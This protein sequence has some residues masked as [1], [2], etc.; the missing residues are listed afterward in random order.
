MHIYIYLCLCVYIWNLERWYWW[1]CL[2]DSN[3]DK[4][5]EPAY[6]HGS[7]EEGEGGMNGESNT[8]TYMLPP[9]KYVATGN[10][11]YYSENSN[12]SSATSERSGKG[13]EGE[14][15]LR[16]REYMCTCDWLLL[17]YG[18][19][20]HN[21]V[22]ILQLKIN[23]FICIYK[24]RAVNPRSH[25]FLWGSPKPGLISSYIKALTIR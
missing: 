17:I 24:K 15:H 8:E 2:Q 1:T 13:G 21:T 12:Q 22:I 9:I 23:K 7:R 6:G 3:R 20:Q 5:R 19:N 11:L 18:R 14:G 4:H 10:L 25:W 16:R